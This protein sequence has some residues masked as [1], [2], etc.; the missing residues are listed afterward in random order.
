MSLPL[1]LLKILQAVKPETLQELRYLL[2][3]WFQQGEGL[4]GPVVGPAIR[5]ARQPR[6]A[7]RQEYVKC[8]KPGCRRATGLGHGPYWYQ[9]WKEGGKVKKRYLGRKRP[10]GDG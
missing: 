5:K 10:G 8:G 3:R 2:N 9:Y 7:L 4:S 6:H 1:E